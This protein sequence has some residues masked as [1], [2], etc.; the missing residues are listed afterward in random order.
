MK[1][2]RILS[3]TSITDIR[4]DIK[5]PDYI[6][7]D[8]VE[9]IETS[10]SID[11]EKVVLLQELF[12]K[13]IMVAFTSMNAVEAIGALQGASDANWSVYCIGTKTAEFVGRYLSNATIIGTAQNAKEL[14][15]LIVEESMADAIYFF[16]G[17]IRRDDLP[18]VLASSNIRLE[19]TIVYDTTMIRE[20]VDANYDAI[21][22]YSPSAV[23]SFF[24]A[25][26]L[27]EETILFAIG[28]T[29]AEALQHY[30]SNKIVIADLTSKL[31]LINKSLEYFKN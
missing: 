5:V 4:A 3:T 2:V 6:V 20:K 27:K 31:A 8:D 28:K 18:N 10:V 24:S 22:F 7:L 13:N 30:S 21:L 1:A 26:K 15:K 16:C 29:T 25:N 14:G 23:E 17:N 12:Q 19:E 11:Q 9:F